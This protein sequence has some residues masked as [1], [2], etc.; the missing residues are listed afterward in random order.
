MLPAASAW[1]DCITP[2]L[3][4]RMASVMCSPPSLTIGSLRTGRDCLPLFQR[5]RW[6]L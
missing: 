6:C 2:G 5:G 3:T 4:T 1:I